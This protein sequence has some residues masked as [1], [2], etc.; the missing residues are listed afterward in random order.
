MEQPGKRRQEIMAIG[1]H[2]DSLPDID[3]VS[4]VTRQHIIEGK[5]VNLALLLSTNVNVETKVIDS[6][7][8]EMKIK[9]D[10]LMYEA[11]P[12]RGQELNLYE[13]DIIDIAHKYCGFTFYEYH[14]SFAAKAAKY[15]EQKGSKLDWSIRDKKLYNTLFSGLRAQLCNICA[16]QMHIAPLFPLAAE[17]TTCTSSR[18]YKPRGKSVDIH[19]CQIINHE[20]KKLCNNYNSAKG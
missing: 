7:T 8:G 17:H 12:M 13:R 3:I 6:L 2:A 19:G 10:L 18:Y 14:K 5:D 11:S 4:Q 16:S 9:P 20:S 15:L 1:M